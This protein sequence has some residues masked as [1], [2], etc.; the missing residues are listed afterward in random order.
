[1]TTRAFTVRVS[2]DQAEELEA[3]AAAEGTSVAEEVRSALTERIAAR[4]KD[5]EF[6]AR[7]RATMERNRRVLD[8]LAE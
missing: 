7:L 4:R 6:Q 8:R 3:I 1:M 5:G 2:E